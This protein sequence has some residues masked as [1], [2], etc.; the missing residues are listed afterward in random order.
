M[1]FILILILLHICHHS[2]EGGN[3]GRGGYQRSNSKANGGSSYDTTLPSIELQTGS[4]GGGGS[5]RDDST[6]YSGGK[7]GAGGAAIRLFAETITING[8][9]LSNGENGEGCTSSGATW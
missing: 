9:I 8:S 2:I 6:E 5:G 7:G 1:R 4:G 3:G